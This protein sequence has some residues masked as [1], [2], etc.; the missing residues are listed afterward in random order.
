MDPLT[1]IEGGR[2]G[3]REARFLTLVLLAI[4]LLGSAAIAA[5]DSSNRASEHAREP[6]VASHDGVSGPS[7]TDLRDAETI[8]AKREAQLLDQLSSQRAEPTERKAWKGELVRT[9]K[10]LED[11]DRALEAARC[12][13]PTRGG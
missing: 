6:L 4:V 8:L 7:C 5:A 12:P 9:K 10:S 11:F 3:R 2:T 1:E 13:A